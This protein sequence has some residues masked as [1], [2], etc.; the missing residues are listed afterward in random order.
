MS[1]SGKRFLICAAVVDEETADEILA[2]ISCYVQRAEHAGRVDTSKGPAY[3]A[4]H[5]PDRPYRWQV[6]KLLLANF[7]AG[8]D[9]LDAGA[10]LVMVP[11]V[12]TVDSATGKIATKTGGPPCEKKP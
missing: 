5:V 9:D 6:A 1:N 8:L 12:G 3:H 2:S 7:L 4:Q 11:L 10:P